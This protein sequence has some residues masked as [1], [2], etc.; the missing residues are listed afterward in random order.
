MADENRLLPFFLDSDSSFE[1]MPEDSAPFIKNLGWDTNANN[2]LPTGTGNPSGEGQNEYTLT[3]TRSNKAIPNTDLPIGFNKNAGAFES[4]ITNEFYYFNYNS[5]GN[6]G[7]YVI[8]GDT[9]DVKKVV[10]DPELEF[11]DEADG[12][13]SHHRVKLRIRY[14]E[15]KNIIEKHLIA[16]NGKSWQKWINVI[17]AIESNGFDA[18][19]NPYWSLYQPHFDRKELLQYAV[20]PPMI[21]PKIEKIPNTTADKGVV[22]QILGY[23][24]EFCEQFIYTDGRETTVSPY[25]LPLITKKTSTISDP[26]VIPKKAKITLY[27]GS[28]M[29]EKINLYY[30]KTA[31]LSDSNIDKTFGDWYLYDTIYKYDS[32]GTNSPEKI[33]DKYWLRENAWDGYNFDAIQNTIEY[34]FDNSRLGQITGQDLFARVQNNIPQLSTALSDIGDAILL[35]GNREGYDNF[36]CEVTDKLSVTYEEDGATS[37]KLATRKIRLYV[38]AGRDRANKADKHSGRMGDIWHSQVGYHVG[39]DKKVRWGGISL[40]GTTVAQLNIDVDESKEFDLDFGDKNGFRCYL[41][42]TPYYSDC[43]WYQV[44]QNL[45][46]VK[47]DGEIDSTD[48]DDTTFL[49]NVYNG[50][51]FF[52]GVFDFT[53]PAGVYVA[54]LGRHNVS[55]DEDYRNK[56]TYIMGIANSKLASISTYSID[57]GSSIIVNT[58][59]PNA[60]VDRSKEMVIDCSVADVDVW[61]NNRDLFYVCTPFNGKGRGRNRWSFI[62]GYLTESETEKI[63]VENFPYQLVTNPI[64]SD[65]GFTDKNGFFWGY[66][67]GG[68]IRHNFANT[69]FSAKINCNLTSFTVT[70]NRDNAAGWKP[71]NNATLASQ[72]GGVVGVNNRII[73][74]GRITDDTGDIG[75]S[76][77]GVSIKGGATTY[78]QSDGYFTLIVH[79]GNQNPL[80]SVIY[81]NAGGLFE[82]T[83]LGCQP[84]FPIPFNE[85]LSPCGTLTSTNPCTGATVTASRQYP[86]CIRQKILVQ[87][88]E[89]TSLKSN[90]TYLTAIV[91]GDLAG[92]V[93]FANIIST[94]RIKSFPER[95]NTL[96]TSFK[97]N[98]SGALELNK[99]NKT[100]DIKWVAFYTTL[101]NNYKKYIQWVGDKIEFI[102]ARGNVT[103]TPSNASLVR[104]DISSLLEYNVSQNLSL[105]SSYEFVKGDRIRVFDNGDGVLFDTTVYGDVID[106]E[107]LG[108]NYNQAAINANI[109]APQTNTVLNST[110]VVGT[111]PTVVYLKYN[112]SF[113]KLKDKTGFWI[114]LYTPFQNQDKVPYF[115]LESFFPIINGE[116]AKFETITGTTPQYSYPTSGSLNFWDTYLIN[117]AISIPNVGLKNLGHAFESPN[118]TDTWGVNA[119]SGGRNNTVNTDAAQTWYVDETIKSDDYVSEGKKNGLGTFR[120]SNKKNF[121]GTQRGDIVA[122]HSTGSNII[123]VC[124]KDWFVVDFNYNFIFANKQGVQVA[125]LNNN[126]GEPHQKIGYNYG[127]AYEHTQTILIHEDFISWYD[128]RNG[129]YIMSNYQQA[130]PISGNLMQSYFIAKA[131]FVSSWNA[132]NKKEKRFDVMS[133]IDMES[134]NIFVTFR[135]RRNN[136]QNVLSFINNRRNTQLDH[137]ETLVYNIKNKRWTRFMGFA[138]E[139]Y[140]ELRGAKSGVQ[141][142]AF[143]SGKPYLHNQVGI[144]DFNTFFGVKTESVITFVPN[145]KPEN[146]KIL[147]SVALD[148][149][150]TKMFSDLVYSNTINS[151]SYIPI[152]Y[153]KVKENMNYA[154]ILRNG[155]T[156]PPAS[157]D[158]N[159]RS[160]IVDGGRIFGN[161]FLVRLVTD[162]DNLQKYFELNAIY[163]KTEDT[164]NNTK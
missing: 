121:K 116:I 82:I 12:Y 125:N 149:N 66:T 70:N 118:I 140:G 133:G 39:D 64:G 107:V 2:Q 157:K 65:G 58:V 42:G 24:F 158:D 35:G 120:S 112:Q 122:M 43:K 105:L 114:E 97:W 147:Q 7:V 137:Q 98:L 1:K 60:I 131:G 32:C 132:Q 36:P 74:T 109:I 25:S 55:A 104:V 134:M 91:G 124:T 26:N 90:G 47:I 94:V 30:R 38:Y 73:V 81:I 129:A 17:A 115:E 141:M 164:G 14:D 48:T 9:L 139:G 5:N 16:T 20:R 154:P 49:S 142:I 150:G 126:M 29:V 113:D 160:M 31:L 13:F 85:N 53:V 89:K 83:T 71:D 21:A 92:R 130:F 146:I 56:S 145:K 93:T 136:S 72:N 23:A 22:N 50:K 103:T 3:P 68:D 138:P 143:A 162:L 119:H 156:Y 67:W 88:A 117:R 46:L 15:N 11:T 99:Y 57:S 28:C 45:E 44:K 79:N 128:E 33:G 163:Y 77:I 51:G 161:Y 127:C 87:D 78:S 54:T 75:Y 95:N 151:F 63:G 61:G 84:L 123:I 153:F 6:H 159:F 148:I 19:L 152:N 8:S 62:E 27:A 18:S 40:E 155:N 76:N 102:D 10:I 111:D 80:Q 34:T 135:P 144:K 106:E 69:L 100:K 52:V 108:S 41:K 110:N 37:C 86:I 101:A 4:A 96:P 59:K